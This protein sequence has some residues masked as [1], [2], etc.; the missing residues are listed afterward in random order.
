MLKIALPNK[1]SLSDDAVQLVREAGYHCR[2]YSRELIVVDNKNQ[3]EFVYLRPR[4]IAIYVYKGILDLGV[5]GRDL[6]LDSG[7][8]VVELLSLGFGQS[9]FYYAVP[10]EADL[11]PDRFNG[12]R[13]ATSY[14]RLVREDLGH[15]GMKAEIINLD[16]AVEISIRLGVADAIADVVQTGRTLKAAGLKVVGQPLLHSEAILVA[17]NRDI[18]QQQAVTPFLERI[19]GI[20]VAREYVM[21]EYDIPEAMLEMACVI[22]PGIESPTVSPLSRKGWV[23]V[24]SMSKQQ[25]INQMMDDLTRIGA[26]GIIVTDIRT[27]RI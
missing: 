13:I 11:H 27:C 24:K 4:D 14:P 19:R 17:R 10:A 1:G 6:T 23:A 5:T 2:R 25:D 21:V 18:A 8:E 22:T 12:M 26:K 20:V 15:R 9:D 7:A 3:V 16:G